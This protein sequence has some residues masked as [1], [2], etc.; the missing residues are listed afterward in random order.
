MP[1]RT[2]VL[3]I[4]F[5]TSRKLTALEEQDLFDA[6]FVQIKEPYIDLKP[7]NFRVEVEHGEL[8]EKKSRR[9]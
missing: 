7:A 9:A 8:R 5:Q 6:A 1:K 3:K 2:Y 4:E